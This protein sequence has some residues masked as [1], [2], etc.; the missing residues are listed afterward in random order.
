MQSSGRMPSYK[1]GIQGQRAA[2]PSHSSFME[3]Q[4]RPA[5][6]LSPSIE[7]MTTSHPLPII[8]CRE[9]PT[10][11]S[12]VRP[13]TPLVLA[14]ATPHFLIKKQ[15]SMTERFPSPSVIQANTTEKRSSNFT[16]N[17]HWWI[18]GAFIFLPEKRLLSTFLSMTK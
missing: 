15:K 8:P 16:A 4:I 13:F 1:P 10:A 5:N 14:S 12:K 6:C 7:M 18:S 3:K 17:S 11:I 9:E 2:L